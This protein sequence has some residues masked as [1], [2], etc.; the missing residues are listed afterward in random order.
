VIDP[1][2]PRNLNPN[3]YNLRLD[4]KLVVYDRAPQVQRA[5][6]STTKVN[7]TATVMRNWN[8]DRRLAK[9]NRTHS[10]GG[11]DRNLHIELTEWK[12]VLDMA[13]D[14]PIYDLEIPEKGL[15]LVPGRLYLAQT[16]E[17]TETHGLVP[18]I[19][20][21][22]SV[23]RLGISIH[24][25]AGFGDI[26]FCGTWT[27]EIAVVEPV[28]IYAGSKFCQISYDTILGEVVKYESKKYQGQREPRPSAIWKEFQSAKTGF[29]K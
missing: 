8:D 13:E 17:Y 22:S 18:C 29:K 24:A 3:S 1:Y 9:H 28:R 25:T 27:L 11:P 10:I 2:D 23:G 15:V 5:S 20:G 7:D 14:N 16:F 26:G 19:D 6:M 21:R 4:K 12:D